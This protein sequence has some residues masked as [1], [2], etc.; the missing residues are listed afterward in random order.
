MYRVPEAVQ[1]CPGDAKH[2]PVTLLRRAGTYMLPNRM[3][4]GPAAHHHSASKTRVNALTVLRSIR[5]TIDFPEP[6]TGQSQRLA[7]VR[8]R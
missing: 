4:P 5:G 3:D 8:A 1:R 7:R 6:L 2:R